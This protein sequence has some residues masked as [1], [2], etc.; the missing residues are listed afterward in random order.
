MHPCG[1][2]PFAHRAKRPRWS[3]RP[4][5]GLAIPWRY[6]RASFGPNLRQES[7]RSMHSR[8]LRHFL[9]VVEKRN[10]TAAADALNISQPALTRSIREL[11]KTVAVRLFER[12]PTGV[13]STKPGEVVA[14]RVKLM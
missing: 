4:R 12:P 3:H 11:E 9:G 8:L 5:F 10:I 13:I 6:G 2:S 7:G 1:Q 14:R